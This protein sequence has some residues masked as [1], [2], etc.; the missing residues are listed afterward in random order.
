[1][2][3]R[4]AEDWRLQGV[5]IALDEDEQKV[6]FACNASACTSTPS[7]SIASSSCRYAWV[8][9]P[10]SVG[11]IGGLGDRDAQALGAASQ[12]VV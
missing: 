2:T 5:G 9:L 1:M 8:S 4:Y 11:R 12:G 10:E 7:N 6:R 3:Y